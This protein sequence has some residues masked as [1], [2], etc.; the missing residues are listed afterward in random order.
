V[1]TDLLIIAAFV[2]YG[3][4]AGSVL[5]L[6]KK[7]RDLPRPYKTYG[8]PIVPVIFIAF[9]LLLLVISFYESPLKS[10]VGAGLILSG[11]P[12]YYYWKR[13]ALA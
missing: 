7:Q 5:I 3:L 9:C 4:V 12:F 8:Y 6:R 13:K 2:F 10:L 1:L 11:L